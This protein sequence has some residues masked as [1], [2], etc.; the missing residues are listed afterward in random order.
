[1]A[2]SVSLK[3][4]Q[5]AIDFTAVSQNGVRF[6]LSENYGKSGTVLI[7]ID[8]ETEGSVSLANKLIANRKNA[9]IIAV[10]VSKLSADEQKKLLGENIL[11]LEKLCFDSADII[12]TYNIGNAP[13]TYFIDKQGLVQNGFVGD[14]KEETINKY[15]DRVSQ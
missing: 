12:E 14:I 3:K 6:T 5:P 9:D 7:F 4:P 15:I 2:V 1:M 11:A 13:I 10:S 8:P